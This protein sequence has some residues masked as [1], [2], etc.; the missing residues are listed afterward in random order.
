MQVTLGIID[1][2]NRFVT[3]QSAF[4]IVLFNMHGFSIWDCA[5]GQ[6]VSRTMICDQNASASIPANDFPSLRLL[7]DGKPSDPEFLVIQELI[8]WGVLQLA[9]D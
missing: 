6:R 3:I 7:M 4:T 5:F 9:L 1:N 2:A 8:E